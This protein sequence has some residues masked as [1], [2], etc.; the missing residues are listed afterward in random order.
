[1]LG[2]GYVGTDLDHCVDSVTGGIEDWAQE[3]LD[4]LRSYSEFSPSG[5]GIHVI[6]RGQ[7]P[8]DGGGRKK[9]PVEMYGTARYFT[10]TGNPVT[11][12]PATIETRTTELA[13]LH[14]RFF[15]ESKARNHR[16]ASQSPVDL[17]DEYVMT[18]ASSA[19][20]GAKFMTLFR[21]DWS[22]YRTQSEAD[23]ALCAILA[24]WT[25]GNPEQVD[26][27]FRCSGLIRDKW[28]ERHFAGG[29]T[30]GER[31]VATACEGEAD[32]PGDSSPEGLDRTDLGNA[33]RF[34][35][36]NPNLRFDHL[37][38]QWF[39]FGQGQRW[40]ADATGR[41]QEV[42]KVVVHE[43]F[44]GV[45]ACPDPAQRILLRR[46]AVRSGQAERLKAMV[47]L[48]QSD[49][50]V[51][52]DGRGWDLDPFLLGV[53]NGVVDLRTGQHRPGRSEDSI[54]KATGVRFN[55]AASCPRFQ[56]FLKEVLKDSSHVIQYIQRALGYS[57]TGSVSEQ[58]LFLG[59]GSGANGKSTLFN[60]IRSVLADYA[61]NLPFS[62]LEHR[63]QTNI[64][65]DLAML[66]GMRFV[67]ASE[68][69]EDTRL[70]E[71]RV[72]ALTGGDPITARYLHREFFEFSPVMKVWLG[73]NHRPMV[74]DTSHAF[75]RRVHL[76]PFEQQFQKNDYLKAEL[77][78]EGEGILRW[79]VEGA[80]LWQRDGLN[81]P[82]SVLTATKDYQAESDTVAQFL[83]ERCVVDP[84][85]ETPANLLYMS[86]LTW[87]GKQGFGEQ[88]P[89]RLNPRTFGSRVSV[90]F[91]KDH[92]RTGWVYKGFR[93]VIPAEPD[94]SGFAEVDE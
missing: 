3:I 21:G 88:S 15:G 80:L 62:T 44:R 89:E 13:Q 82:D 16:T 74:R 60:A 71:A 93:L 38:R 64:P 42:A 30:Y 66:P 48:S 22:A 33:R 57:L 6:V 25:N 85:G 19:A 28:D 58:V 79:M 46:W 83:H 47:T 37:R 31:T 63:Q 49:P 10:M 56:R 92:K 39:I 78:A 7:L 24:F 1:M 73:V 4:L 12:T 26:R 50:S 67:T 70:N 87:C 8:G 86:Y 54:T 59:Y 9:G 41:A 69:D 84:A 11:G 34:V 77:E 43:R 32:S 27:L 17:S 45:V 53:Q 61:L 35:E 91:S 36:A 40:V 76:I 94:D 5:T 51:A 65:N 20:N 75:W 90:Q 23:L 55:A 72:K 52:V 2:E 14:Q 68:T 81:A 18:Q 29:Q